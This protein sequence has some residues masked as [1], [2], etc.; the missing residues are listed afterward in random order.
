MDLGLNFLRPPGPDAAGDREEEPGG[1]EMGGYPAS[2]CYN[3]PMHGQANAYTESP[4]Q[5]RGSTVETRPLKGQQIVALQGAGKRFNNTYAV[6]NASVS[7]GAGEMLSVVGPVGAGKSTLLKMVFGLLK[8]DEGTVS[9]YGSD[10]VHEGRTHVGYLPERPQ[11]HEN[12]TGEEYLQF[13]ARL[14]GLR[15]PAAKAAAARAVEITGLGEGAKRRIGMYAP[16]MVQRL[17]LGVALVSVDGEPHGLLVLDELS[18]G[19]GRG[20]QAAA[21]EVL[22][23][24]RRKG[25]AVLLASNRITEVERAC[26]RMAIMREGNIVLQREVDNAPRIILLA[27]PPLPL[28]T[29]TPGAT[30]RQ[31]MRALHSEAIVSGP[32]GEGKPLVTSLPAPPNATEQANLKAMALRAVL[33]AGWEV[34]YMAVEN[35]ELESIYM[36]AMAPR[37]VRPLPS[38]PRAAAAVA[39]DTGKLSGLAGQPFAVEVQQAPM[40]EPPSPNGLHTGTRPLPGTEAQ[41]ALRAIA[42]GEQEHAAPATREEPAAAESEVAAAPEPR[43]YG[44]TEAERANREWWR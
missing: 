5:G 2:P 19:L 36:E 25:G 15:G 37:E 16:E 41:A 7:L 11:Y 3:T 22:A 40:P 20:S 23:E 4:G 30:V 33:D 13:H 38:R 26:T 6:R 1:R 9:L 17:G 24:F 44:A 43:A 42:N 29:G 32:D 35:R 12:F 10:D 18:S 34:A 14:S 39:S 27:R 21:R 31:A 28:G 8:P